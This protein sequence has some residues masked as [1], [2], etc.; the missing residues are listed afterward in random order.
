MRARRSKA[1]RCRP[2]KGSRSPRRPLRRASSFAA[3]RRLA[4]KCSQAFG[5]DL[6]AKLGE[7]G[8]TNSRAALWLGPDEWLLIAEGADPGPL[9]IGARGSAAGGA[10]E[11]RRRLRP[12]DRPPRPRRERGA[13][14]QRRLP[15]RPAPDRFPD[16]N[17]DTDDLRQGRDRALA[18]RRGRVPRRGLADLCALPRRGPDRSGQGSAQRLI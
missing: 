18:P 8:E 5:A 1:L 16:P 4:S 3:T 2:G 14:A 6:P 17:G 7:A 13:G 9:G 11:P 10:A 12:P 15:A